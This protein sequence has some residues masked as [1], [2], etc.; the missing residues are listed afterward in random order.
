MRPSEALAAGLSKGFNEGL[1]RQDRRHQEM[2]QQAA[3][4]MQNRKD[5]MALEQR[6]KEKSLEARERLF[7]RMGTTKQFKDTLDFKN[8]EL[9]YKKVNDEKDRQSYVFGYKFKGFTDQID[10][11]DWKKQQV[12]SIAGNNPSPTTLR[13]AR[14]EINKLDAEKVIIQQK[15]DRL[16][17]DGDVYNQLRNPNEGARETMQKAVDNVMPGS[18]RAEAIKGLKAKYS[19]TNPNYEPTE[20]DI[21]WW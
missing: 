1:E 20:E 11:I 10:N 12:I 8:K 21:N 3:V 14:E 7:E 13:L 16:M 2:I 5:W 4:E 9:D 15:R 19:K 17:A 18:K 6:K